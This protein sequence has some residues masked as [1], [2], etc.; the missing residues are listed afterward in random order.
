[1]RAVLLRSLLVI[2]VGGLVLAG[3]LY[4]A[5]TVDARPPLVV[6]I[7]VTQ[8]VSG[9]PGLALIT[10]SIEVAFSE[11]VEA[12]DAAGAIRLEPPVEGTASWSGST[13]IFTPAEALELSTTYEVSVETGIRDLAGNVM[14]EVPSPFAF[15]TAGRP[16][17]V[18]TDPAEGAT[19]VPVEQTIGITFSTL[20]DTAAV[21]EAIRVSPTISYDLR[22][23]G[24]QLDIV[25]SEPLRPDTAYEVSLSGDATDAAGVAIE[26]S[27]AVTFSTVEPGLRAETM[28]PGDG[29]DGIAPATA[30]AIIFDRPIDPGSVADDVLRI[31]PDVA[32][33]LEVVAL[34]GE[35]EDQGAAGRLLRFT[36]S[37]PLPPNTTFSVEVGAD[38]VSASGG[39]TLAQSLSWSFTTG[40][41]AATLSNQITFLTRRSGVANVWAM[42]ADGTGQHQVSAELS[43]VLDYAVAPDGSSLIVADGR[44]LVFL[45]ADGADR[46][47]I[48]ADEHW[49]FDPAYAPSG[50]VIAFGRADA[51]SGAGLGLWQ[52]E[53]G[54]GEPQPIELPDEL[55]ASPTPSDS[56][57][58]AGTLLRTPRYSPDG[59]ALAFVDASGAVGL[60]ELPAQR[61]TRV[62]F[63]TTAPPAWL[64]D[65]S[66]VLLGG[67]PLE[68][69][70]EPPALVAPVE[71]LRPTDGDAVHRL[72]RSG[73]T[74]RATALG[75]G[76]RVLAVAGDGTIAF[77]TA[78]GRLGTT[79]DVEEGG[80]DLLV[81]DARIIGAAFAPGEAAMVIVVADEEATEGSIERLDLLGRERTVL[82]TEGWQPRWLP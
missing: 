49:D 23:S 56:E 29:V 74:I 73:I 65:S 43:P 7:S 34:P 4:V 8:P 59:L 15:E 47:V 76:W 42:N 24:E 27:F 17:I 33:S 1:M 78:R 51:T 11:P 50:R 68:V 38:I 37:G 52:W 66:A 25:P 69:A 82:A 6:G 67:S 48:T 70:G 31:T 61:L 80:G 20:M 75:T 18:A 5:S 14:T 21:E 81:D 35:R 13:L 53:V 71:P 57:Q 26:E 3:L 58:P 54:G 64:P 55:A 60:L 19:Q 12:D 2:G 63:A 30:I 44:H 72:A 9:D 32:G 10:T 79:L 77:A 45:R 62:E 22:W 28:V 36:P 40:A 41:P 16:R 39:G 46:R